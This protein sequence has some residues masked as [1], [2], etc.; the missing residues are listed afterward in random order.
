MTRASQVIQRL[1]QFVRKAGA[2]R[3]SEEVRQTV[4][5]A[6]ALAL[7]GAEAREVRL[8]TDFAP[9]TPLVLIDKVQ[10]QQV[11]VNLIRNAVEAMQSSQRRELI[12]RTVMSVDAMVE[13]S[14]ADSGPG[15]APDVRSRLFQPFVTTKPA[16]MGVGLSICRGIVEA[17]GGRMWIADND[18][19]GADFRFTLP[20]SGADIV[21]PQPVIEAVRA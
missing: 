16:G 13:V 5:E 12:I 14:V 1:R 10:I 17:H 6:A 15:L 7:L 4:E 20:A 19:G 21:E 9:D 11:L 18:G 2:Q 8:T 3:S